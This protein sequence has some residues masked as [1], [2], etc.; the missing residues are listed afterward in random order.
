MA[1]IKHRQTDQQQE[2][3]MDLF[4]PGMTALHRAGLAGLWMTLKQFERGDARLPGGSWELTARTVTLRW[5][6]GKT[7]AF[8]EALFKRSFR[9]DKRSM[10]WLTA[11]GDPDD[12]L[13]SAVVLNEALLGTFLQQGLT[14]KADPARQPTGTASVEIEPFTVEFRKVSS[15]A[16]QTAWRDLVGRG[17][18]LRTTRLAGWHFPGGA[19]RHVAFTADTALEEP[20]QRVLPLIYAP[21]GGIYFQ[22]YKRR[23]GRRPQYALVLPEIFDLERYANVRA[24][25]LQ[26][27]VRDLKAGGS[28][29]A[30]WRVLA[31]L[32][33]KGLLANLDTRT[34]RVIS[35]GS[36]AWSKQQKT[37]IE[38]FSVN[39]GSEA[40]LRTFRLCLNV[41]R[42]RFVRPAGGD[43]RGFWDVPQMPELIARNLAERRPWYSGFADYVMKESGSKDAGKRL[44]WHLVMAPYRSEREGLS[45]MVSEA[46]FEDER[47]RT[48]VRACHEAWRRRLG[49]LGER[50]KRESTPFENLAGREFERLRV[51]FARCKNAVTLREVVTSFWARAGG[52]LPELATGWEVVLPLL[53]EK[54]WRKAKDLAL[55]ALASYQR[56]PESSDATGRDGR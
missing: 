14:R 40:S 13:Q 20:P 41:F 21:V 38:L 28:V 31:T 37:R 54:N 32:E 23:E 10:I 44:L 11:L 52:P 39:A 25:M 35:F 4:S 2:L 18:H 51:G 47:D 3:V 22:I 16:H 6:A 42:T 8:F 26:H 43:G 50:A 17:G 19:V 55:L 9:I 15:Y 46:E 27:G 53:D 29:E 36:V 48:F 5:E 7:Q 49:Q 45:K 34:C 30:G 33:A 12:H 1:K 24:V 56:P